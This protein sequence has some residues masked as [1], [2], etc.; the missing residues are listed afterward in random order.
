MTE[1]KWVCIC[2]IDTL[3]IFLLLLLK[4][5]SSKPKESLAWEVYVQEIPQMQN[6]FKVSFK[7]HLYYSIMIGKGLIGSLPIH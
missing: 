6:D 1:F 3:S 2:D 4:N 7:A 5:A